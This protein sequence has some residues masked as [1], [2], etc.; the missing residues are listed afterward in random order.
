MVTACRAYFRAATN[1]DVAIDKAVARVNDLMALDM[2][3][4][5]FVTLALCMLEPQKHEL[6]LFFSGARANP[7]LAMPVGQV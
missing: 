6:H 1:I 3:S 2:P 7:L 4:G 5:R